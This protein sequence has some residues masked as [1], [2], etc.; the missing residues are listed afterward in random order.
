MLQHTLP[1]LNFGVVNKYHILPD[2]YITIK[3][4]HYSICL[5][6]ANDYSISS[7]SDIFAFLL[8]LSILAPAI[9]LQAMNLI[10]E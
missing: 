1:S 4:N 6:V 2:G 5:C 3:K 10:Q 9:E 8:S 7:F